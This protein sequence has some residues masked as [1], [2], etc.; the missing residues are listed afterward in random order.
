MP[1]YV[2]FKDPHPLN[3]GLARIDHVV[4]NV[5][6]M[7]KVCGDIKTWTGFHTFAFFTPD[8]IK[9]DY[10]SLNSEVLASDDAQVLMP[11]NEPAPGKKESQI[12]KYLRA[13]QGP[14][15]QH[16]AIKTPN[17]FASIESMA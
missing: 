15:V 16:I 13:Y 11:I 9:T 17:I 2:E 7:S 8:Q 1:G 3:Y 4:G 14:G 6:R 5:Y 12:L 10:T